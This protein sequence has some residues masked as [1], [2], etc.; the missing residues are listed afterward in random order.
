M[1]QKIKQ[2]LASKKCLEENEEEEETK[3]KSC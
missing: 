1:K 2:N 3:H